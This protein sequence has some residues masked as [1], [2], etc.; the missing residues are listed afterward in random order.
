[1]EWFEYLIIIAAV[2]FVFLVIFFHFYLK[3]KGKSLTSD[4]SG[5]CSCCH[6]SCQHCNHA[7]CQKMLEEYHQINK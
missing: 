2:S 1:M 3:R 4:C 6:G 5:N 7:S